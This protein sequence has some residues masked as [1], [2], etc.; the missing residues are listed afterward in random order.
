MWTAVAIVAWIIMLMVLVVLHELGH[1]WAAKK[2]WVKVLEFGVGIP[3]KVMKLWTDK[4]GTEYTLNAIPLGWFVRLKWEDPDNE[5]EFLAPDSLITASLWRKIVILLAGI[6]MNFIV[7]YVIFVIVFMVGVRPIQVVSWGGSMSYLLP[8]AGSLYQLWYMDESTDTSQV[9]IDQIVSGGVA[10][11]LWLKVWDTVTHV[12]WRR[13]TP[14]LF[15]TVLQSFAWRAVDLTVLSK[16]QSTNTV[17]FVCTDECMLWVGISYDQHNTIVPLRFWW[18]SFVMAWKEL[19]MQTH[20]TLQWLQK[21]GSSLISF[22]ATKTKS[23]LKSMSGPAWVIKAWQTIFATW[24]WSS[25]L[26]FAWLI[27]LSLALFNLLPI[28][29]LD[30]GRVVWSIIQ[31]VGRFKPQKYFVIEWYINMFFFATLMLLWIYILWQDLV[32]V[33]GLFGG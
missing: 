19:Q 18:D 6:T 9:T 22:D 10:Q 8:S 23:W 7:T 21:I 3:P 33:W 31:A 27:S 25:Y 26:A 15:S 20:N 14:V 13:V 32:R 11:S 16:D 2:L 29:A 4:D 5:E 30:G 1:F 24:G 17:T 12:W 28:P